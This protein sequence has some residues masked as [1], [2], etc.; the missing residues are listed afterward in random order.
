MINKCAMHD[1]Q[2]ISSDIYRIEKKNIFLNLKIEYSIFILAAAIVS[3]KNSLHYAFMQ[4]VRE[5]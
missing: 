4:R 3:S 1:L 5:R 2:Q